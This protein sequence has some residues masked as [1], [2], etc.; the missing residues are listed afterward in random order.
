MTS[1]IQDFQW[2]DPEYLEEN[3][4]NPNVMAEDKYEAMKE[5]MKRDPKTFF[6]SN[7]IRVTPKD[8]YYEDPDQ[9][10]DRRCA[11]SSDTFPRLALPLRRA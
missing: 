4:F 2:I 6:I 10:F 9:P 5:D 11:D 3:P 8:A 1:D 7:M